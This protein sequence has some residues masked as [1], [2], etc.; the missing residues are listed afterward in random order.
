MKKYISRTAI[1][2]VSS[3]ILYSCSLTKRVPD[4]EQLLMKNEIFKNGKKLAEHVGYMR[5]DEL[6]SIIEEHK[7]AD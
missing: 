4:G 2:I 3:L 1:V 5:A 6:N 7:D